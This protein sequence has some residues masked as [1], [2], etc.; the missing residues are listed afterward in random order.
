M[1]RYTGWTAHL[2]LNLILM[3]NDYPPSIIKLENRL[4]YFK[5]VSASS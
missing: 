5:Q 1:S 4:N 2:L 3:Q